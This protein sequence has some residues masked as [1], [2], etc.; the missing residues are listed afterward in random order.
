MPPT[1]AMIEADL[2]A[3]DWRGRL[4]VLPLKRV[5][6][7]RRG[8]QSLHLKP[9]RTTADR[10]EP[11]IVVRIDADQHHGQTDARA[12]V[13]RLNAALFDGKLYHEPSRR[14]HAAYLTI[15]FA[16]YPGTSVYPSAKRINERV[17]QLQAAL[18]ALAAAWGFAAT[19]EVNGRFAQLGRRDDGSR[20]LLNAGR[21][22]RAPRCAGAG[23]VDTLIGSAF[24][25]DVVGRAVI[26]AGGVQAP[27]PAPAPEP[28]ARPRPSVPPSRPTIDQ[29]LGALAAL[30]STGDKH[31]DRCRCMRR[32]LRTLLGHPRSWPAELTDEQ[33]GRAV[34]L[35]NEL[36][37]A[38]GMAT[39]ARDAKRDA[40]FGRIARFVLTAAPTSQDNGR[41]DGPFFG[42]DDLARAAEL[43]RSLIPAA[44]L[45]A[46]NDA[47]AC[48]A[49]FRS[50]RIDY[51]QLALCLCTV[52]KNA[53]T[54]AGACPTSA[55]SGMF[56]WF[57]VRWTNSTIATM[58]KLLMAAGLIGHTRNGSYKPGQ[59]CRSFQPTAQAW[60]LPFI[61]HLAPDVTPD[62][63]AND[64]T[65]GPSNPLQPFHFPS[66]KFTPTLEQ[67]ADLYG[68]AYFAALALDRDDQPEIPA[69]FGPFDVAPLR[70]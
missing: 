34:D 52:T 19:V 9:K 62:A 63:P 4:D 26:A 59:W 67:D 32:A 1:N 37:V 46:I 23:D 64:V 44:K 13:E 25:E 42:V 45:D 36:Y 39:G 16:P 6:A 24:G 21:W 22:F 18:V 50:V 65:A 10:A 51:A 2:N 30:E 20:K 58:V 5:A 43:V 60:S 12:L 28:T 33:A 41:H 8:G 48:R 54:S 3:A 55:I 66:M 7:F 53:V 29:R 61:Q 14:G 27:A 49:A 38:A 40:A 70:A 11:G 31:R 47:P 35:A 69:A 56:A 57:G 68:D 15:A 17:D